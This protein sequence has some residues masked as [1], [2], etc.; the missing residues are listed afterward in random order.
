MRTFL[1]NSLGLGEQRCLFSLPLG[2]HLGDLRHF[3][4][5]AFGDRIWF[6]QN[7]ELSAQIPIVLLQLI[8]ALAQRLDISCEL[9]MVL[10]GGLG[11]LLELLILRSVV[12]QY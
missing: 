12:F 6:A 10:L 11:R 1:F 5:N 7:I 9:L 4:L 8:L 3:A 2:L